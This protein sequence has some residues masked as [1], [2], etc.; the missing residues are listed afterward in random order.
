MYSISTCNCCLKRFLRDS[1]NQCI[2]F[3]KPI[4][5]MQYLLKNAFAQIVLV[6]LKLFILISNFF[7]FYI[8]CHH[9]SDSLFGLFFLFIILQPAP[10][11]LE[12]SYPFAFFFHKHAV[13][14]FLMFA[15]LY[16]LIFCFLSFIFFNHEVTHQLALYLPLLH[17][18]GE[19]FFFTLEFGINS[20]L[21]SRYLQRGIIILKQTWLK[22]IK[23][24]QYYYRI[25]IKALVQFG[26]PGPKTSCI[27]SSS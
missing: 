2:S 26:I 16:P 9:Y 27:R 24:Y 13:I 23:I 14:F 11:F 4:S 17:I 19:F 8:C 22:L 3:S 12:F 21:I 18:L 20:I 5:A 10:M 25:A 7:A 6:T 15:T 1:L